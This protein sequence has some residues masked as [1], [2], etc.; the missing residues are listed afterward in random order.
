[1]FV[2]HCVDPVVAHAPMLKWSTMYNELQM[3]AS[4]AQAEGTEG[5][6]GV[7]GEVSRKVGRGGLKRLRL[8][9]Q[10]LKG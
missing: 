7:E 4:G 8:R 9:V 10:G 2:P 6:G 3:G 1:M 5:V